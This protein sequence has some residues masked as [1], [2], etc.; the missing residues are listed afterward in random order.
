MV[1][2]GCGFDVASK[3]ELDQ[4]LKYNIN[5]EN[6]VFANPCK[7]NSHIKFAAG[8]KR[9]TSVWS[10]FEPIWP[11]WWAI[12]LANQVKMMTFDNEHELKKIKKL[13]PNAQGEFRRPSILEIAIYF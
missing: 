7:P 5:K 13:H 3:K 12:I 8:K 11:S 1:E 4:V 6:I 10:Q 9:F 2:N